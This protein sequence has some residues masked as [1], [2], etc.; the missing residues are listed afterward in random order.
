MCPPHPQ[1]Q[2]TQPSLSTT[3]S[4]ATYEAR[5][6]HAQVVRGEIS[7]CDLAKEEHYQDVNYSLPLLPSFLDFSSFYKPI[8]YDRGRNYTG[9]RRVCVWLWLWPWLCVC[10]RASV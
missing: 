2:V 4:A 5:T 8:S 7:S 6:V 1:V 3:S 9:L 10:A